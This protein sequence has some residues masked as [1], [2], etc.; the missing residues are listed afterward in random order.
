MKNLIDYLDVD[1][2]H[3]ILVTLIIVW[4]AFIIKLIFSYPLYA[5]V[6]LVIYTA[7]IFNHFNKHMDD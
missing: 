5:F 1:A 2:D 3:I 7:Y 6:C 4:L